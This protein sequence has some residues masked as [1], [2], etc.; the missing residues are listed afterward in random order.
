VLQIALFPF[1]NGIGVKNQK[2]DEDI[3]AEGEQKHNKQ[4][5]NH[6]YKPHNII[7]ARIGLQKEYKHERN[8][9]TRQNKP[10]EQPHGVYFVRGQKQ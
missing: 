7:L 6:K 9:G 3:R 2:G 4:R 5:K 1:K 8:D 10:G